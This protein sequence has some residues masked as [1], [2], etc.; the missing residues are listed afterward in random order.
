MHH[1]ELIVLSER[2]IGEIGDAECR[3]PREIVKDDSRKR[4][5][6][7]V[8][9]VSE[10]EGSA[11]HRTAFRNVQGQHKKELEAS[12]R[13][14]KELEVQMKTNS[15]RAMAQEAH[16]NVTSREM[17]QKYNTA[18]QQVTKDNGKLYCCVFRQLNGRSKVTKR[19]TKQ[20]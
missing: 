9:Q 6:R 20:L 4:S 11:L 19:R 12:S 2:R 17:T 3:V 13:R 16:F 10:G 15:D 5:E 14:I 7:G 1:R 18:I 8:T